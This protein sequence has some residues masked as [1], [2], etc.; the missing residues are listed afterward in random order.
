MPRSLRTGFIAILVML[1]RVTVPAAQGAPAD[2]A[3]RVGAVADSLMGTGVLDNLQ[4]SI[5]LYRDAAARF[6][7]RGDASG[8]AY[9]L[10]RL[11]NLFLL[12]HR[13]DSALLTYRVALPVRLTTPDTI[14]LGRLLN[15]IG[16]AFADLNQPDSALA[17]HQAA[18]ATF[19]STGN[20]GEEAGA[21]L[22]IGNLYYRHGEVDSALAYYKETARL[23]EAGGDL[24]T[25]AQVAVNLGPILEETGFPDSSLAA[26]RRALRLNATL[27]DDEVEESAYQNMGSVFSARL[28]GDSAQYYTHR[29][30]AIAKRRQ[31][32]TT[33]GQLL[34]NLGVLFARLAVADSARWYLS[35]A[36]EAATASGDKRT[37]AKAWN[38]FGILAN[39]ARSFDSAL[40]Y[41]RN[42][43]QL[44]RSLGDR[45]G[46]A[47][48]ALNGAVALKELGQVDSALAQLRFALGVAREVE[49][50]N[51]VGAAFNGIAEIHRLQGRP[52]SA[53]AYYRADQEISR[54]LG[55]LVGESLSLHG[56][57]RELSELGRV[58]ESL[59]AFDSATVLRARAG[60]RAGGDFTRTSLAESGVELYEEWI[61]TWLGNGSGDAE[62]RAYGSLAASDRG[63]AQ[64]LL[65]LMQDSSVTLQPGAD[66]AQ[67]GRALVGAVTEQGA[68]LLA[69]V[70]T[71]DTLVIWWA[72]P[73]AGILVLRT[74]VRRDSLAELI[75]EFRRALQVDG[76]EG[77]SR[78]TPLERGVTS[79]A[80]AR[81]STR[82]LATISS[83]L[84]R[85]V[86]P[87]AI[88]NRLRGI[89]EIVIVP[90]GALGLLPFTAMN[91][92]EGQ[93]P[94]GGAV[95]VRYAPS[96]AALMTLQRGAGPADSAKALVIGNPT[97]PSVMGAAGGTQRLTPL[98]G[99]EA[100]AIRIGGQLG[101]RA[102]TGQQASESAVRVGLRSAPV[103]HLATHG[104]AY[105]DAARARQSFVALAPDSSNDGLLTVGDLLDDPGLK[106]RAELVVLSACQTGLGNLREAEGTIGLQRAFLARG[107]R[108]V[109]VSLWNVP[110][111]ATSRL[112]DQ[113]YVH[114]RSD[115]DH[116]DKAESLRRAQEAVRRAP[117]FSHPRYWAGFQVVGAR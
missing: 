89:R 39:E 41:F 60:R 76:V 7:S 94:L 19:A 68:A 46:V 2:S 107:A 32:A 5:P 112:M 111:Q 114:W 27:R 62:A 17:S 115:S 108:S 45:R 6:R 1:G 61:L 26:S 73:G 79:S 13:P 78:G 30:L 10:V 113:F 81:R 58:A 51:L 97:M 71:R 31:D 91:G 44:H 70:A 59:A 33:Q 93:S 35:R 99:A 16:L 14:R 116:P 98:P 86:L 38:S 63:R 40:V 21:T 87:S 34:L 75:A 8:E 105:S 57:A 54:N 25:A 80:R 84:S 22:N 66:L 72:E 96:L 52:D 92:A 106:L 47:I 9:H 117:G 74:A 29:A 53:L 65:D 82:P 3:Q 28:Q 110:D 100:E 37:A 103:V 56:V 23:A 69:Y 95:A 49:E 20:Q 55:D 15:N 43:A 42:S 104:F 88:G 102:L 4:R 64:A 24:L 109:L 36:R 90:Q 101:V 50:Q 11:G 48:A 67:E 83:E 77:A 85:L 18:R 12:L